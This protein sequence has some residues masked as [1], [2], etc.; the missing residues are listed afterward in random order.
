MRLFYRDFGFAA[1]KPA[2]SAICL[3]KQL[4]I[5]NPQSPAGLQFTASFRYSTRWILGNPPWMGFGVTCWE[6]YRTVV[7]C[8]AALTD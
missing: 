3:F 7:V 6:K 5:P 1:K 4:V 2:L 8:L